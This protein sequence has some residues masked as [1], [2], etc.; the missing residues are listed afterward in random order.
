MHSAKSAIRVDAIKYKLPSPVD[1]VLHCL[2]C[3]I[4]MLKKQLPRALIVYGYA[5]DPYLL[6]LSHEYFGC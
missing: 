4:E 3:N 2:I 5:P 1:V 6:Q